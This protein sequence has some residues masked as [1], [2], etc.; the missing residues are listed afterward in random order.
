MLKKKISIMISVQNS[1][2][3]WFLSSRSTYYLS[4]NCWHCSAFVNKKIYKN[5]D[6]LTDDF[7]FLIEVFEKKFSWYSVI[8]SVFFEMILNVFLNI[9]FSTDLCFFFFNVISFYFVE[10]SQFISQLIVK[11]FCSFYKILI[12]SRFLSLYNFFF[13]IFTNV[14]SRF[15]FI[16]P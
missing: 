4:M 12:F 6:F 7:I 2:L 8:D 1:A 10:K 5:I 9:D 15:V 13:Y 14:E 3:R 16:I 11:K